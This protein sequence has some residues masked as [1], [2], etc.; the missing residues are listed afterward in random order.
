MKQD[1]RS[2]TDFV[3]L[4]VSWRN[5]TFDAEREE[6]LALTK[7]VAAIRNSC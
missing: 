5:A 4:S 6:T 3:W 2:R 1:E 7:T